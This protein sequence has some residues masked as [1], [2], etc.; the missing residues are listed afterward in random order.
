MIYLQHQWIFLIIKYLIKI[1]YLLWINKNLVL[2]AFLIIVSK[3]LEILTSFSVL[4][5]H[6]FW[7][8]Y[9]QTNHLEWWI[10]FIR[11]AKICCP[12]FVLIYIVKEK[13]E[14]NLLTKLTKWYS[15][16]IFLKILDFLDLMF[17][18]YIMWIK[19][20]HFIILESNNI[21]SLTRNTSNHSTKSWHLH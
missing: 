4:L 16:C 8:L 2:Y 9:L 1:Q 12:T 3:H 18:L 11:I 7:P 5:Y 10:D 13:A 15:S 20:N 19:N 6:V 21:E 14:R 17:F